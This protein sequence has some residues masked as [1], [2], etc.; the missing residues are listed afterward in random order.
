M[1][2][3]KARVLEFAVARVQVA[4]EPILGLKSTVQSQETEVKGRSAVEGTVE[5][6]TKI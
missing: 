6:K 5:G 1:L 3:G 4:E 2:T